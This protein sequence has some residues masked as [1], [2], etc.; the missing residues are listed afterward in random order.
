MEQISIKQ[1]LTQA[2]QGIWLAE[3]LGQSGSDFNTAE[4]VEINGHVQVDVLIEAIT[5]TMMEAEGL[6]TTFKQET[7]HVSQILNKPF[8][9]SIDLLD[10]SKEEDPHEAAFLWMEKSRTETQFSFAEGP[11]FQLALLKVGEETYYW[12]LC[13]HHLVIDGYGYTLLGESHC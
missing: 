2:Q 4:Y 11:L 6:Y 12:Y 3:T 9:P 8:Q 7:D 13:I 5:Q 1:K 10:M